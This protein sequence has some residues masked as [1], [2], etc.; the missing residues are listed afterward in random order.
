MSVY[1]IHL[2]GGILQ[3]M[4]FVNKKKLTQINL[5]RCSQPLNLKFISLPKTFDLLCLKLN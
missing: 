1:N 2:R 3:R 5:I 4:Y